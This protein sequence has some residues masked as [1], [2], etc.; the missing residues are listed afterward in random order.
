MALVQRADTDG[1]AAGF[2]IG[3][4]RVRPHD[5]D[6]SGEL[7]VRDRLAALGAAVD[8]CEPFERIRAAIDEAQR[9]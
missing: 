2:V 7:S 8:L 3:A 6:A 1:A 5:A 9:H 4:A